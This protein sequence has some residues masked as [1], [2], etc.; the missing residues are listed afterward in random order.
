MLA[1]EALNRFMSEGE[2]YCIMNLDKYADFIRKRAADD[3]AENNGENLDEF[4]TITQTIGLIRENSIG[5]D[6]QDRL[7]L[8]DKA[9]EELLE[10]VTKRIYNSG[11]AK[12]A[13]KNLIECAW[14][15]EKNEMVFWSK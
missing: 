12:L 11:L 10:A 2:V 5:I 6:E 4:V 1:E 13:S 7:M 8:D 9:Y 3:L 14:D 15:D